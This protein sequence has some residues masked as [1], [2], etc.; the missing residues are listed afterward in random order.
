M[1]AVERPRER[2]T[3]RE[4]LGPRSPGSFPL[5]PRPS[6]AQVARRRKDP[7][8]SRRKQQ[9]GTLASGPL[10]AR[11]THA[12]RSLPVS[13]P[14]LASTPIRGRA[15][16][17]RTGNAQILSR[18]RPFASEFRAIHRFLAHA[19]VRTPPPR[20]PSH[21]PNTLPTRQTHAA[22][23][24]AALRPRSPERPDL[25]AS[26]RNNRT[27][28]A[29]P[30]G[31]GL[32]RLRSVASDLRHARADGPR[33]CSVRPA[34]H[35]LLLSGAIVQPVLAAH[36]L[37]RRAPTTPPSATSARAPGA[38]ITFPEKSQLRIW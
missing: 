17:S 34:H 9:D 26:P 15:R 18:P 7:P 33:S 22:T 19:T 25:P 5:L 21:D 30:P 16:S 28:R 13:G 24:G 14:P 27:R 36:R 32:W 20:R 3:H 1:S 6:A 23:D 35:A 11:R 37:R 12:S 10:S 4:P 2:K 38:G 31:S 8:K 29:H